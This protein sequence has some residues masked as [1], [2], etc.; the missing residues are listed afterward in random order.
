MDSVLRDGLVQS[1]LRMRA[2]SGIGAGVKLAGLR[3]GA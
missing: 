2:L 3:E 1:P